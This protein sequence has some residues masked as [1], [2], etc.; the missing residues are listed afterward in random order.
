M[1]VE[2]RTEEAQENLLLLQVGELLLQVG[3]LIQT[4]HPSPL[5]VLIIHLCPHNT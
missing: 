1:H 4:L 2:K 3:H 5:T